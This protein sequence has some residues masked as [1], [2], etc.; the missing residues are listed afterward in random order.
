MSFLCHFRCSAAKFIFEEKFEKLTYFQTAI[1]NIW[2]KETNTKYPELY[3]ENLIFPEV[4]STC[5]F[6]I[7]KGRNIKNDVTSICFSSVWKTFIAHL[8]VQRNMNKPW[9]KQKNYSKLRTS[10]CWNPTVNIC[11]PSWDIASKLRI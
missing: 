1:Q 2:W 5:S 4:I 3:F 11:L 6:R 8:V 7:W 10:S 9:R